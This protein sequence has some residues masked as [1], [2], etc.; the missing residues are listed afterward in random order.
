[1]AGKGFF[2]PGNKYG[3]GRPRKVLTKPELLLPA[4]LSQKNVNWQGD[5]VYLYR[6]MKERLLTLEEKNQLKFLL[7]LLPYLVTKVAIKDYD[8]GSSSSPQASKE[9][10]EETA[11]LLKEL[12]NDSK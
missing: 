10:A 5:L 3:K 9:M 8:K 11:K 2:Q 6:R 7:E 12:E 1:M 4:V